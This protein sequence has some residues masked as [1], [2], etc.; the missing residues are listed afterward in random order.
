MAN[1]LGVTQKTAWF[2]LQR[3]RE[4]R[5]GDPAELLW[6]IVDLDEACI[7]GKEK[8]NHAD[9]RLRS[10]RARFEKQPVLGMRERSGRSLARPVE[11]TDKAT[12]HVQI[13]RYVTPERRRP[14]RRAPRLPRP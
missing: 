4:A 2:M 12:L 11:K 1:E 14:Y 13:A 7:G 3:L 9:K 10:G 5:G 6:G 8:N